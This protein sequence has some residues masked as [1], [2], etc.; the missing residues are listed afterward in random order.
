MKTSLL[1]VIELEYNN[2]PPQLVALNFLNIDVT[3]SL[4]EVIVSQ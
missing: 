4:I 3:F 2:D 1:N